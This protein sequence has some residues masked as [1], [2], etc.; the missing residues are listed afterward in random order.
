MIYLCIEFK[1]LLEK[2][3]GRS[4]MSPVDKDTNVLDDK[5][6]AVGTMP[7]SENKLLTNENVTTSDK[8]QKCT[9]KITT[10]EEVV[11][12]DDEVHKCTENITTKE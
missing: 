12:G 4:I 9:E 3:N 5:K 2:V 10:S 6:E 1:S 11:K 7:L 8:V